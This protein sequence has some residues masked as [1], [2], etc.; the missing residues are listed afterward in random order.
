MCWLEMYP[1]DFYEMD[2]ADQ[3]PGDVSFATLDKLISFART[4]ALHDMKHKAKRVRERL[5]RVAQNGG[6]KSEILV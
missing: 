6:L 2:Q 4:R 1:E 3:N 5:R